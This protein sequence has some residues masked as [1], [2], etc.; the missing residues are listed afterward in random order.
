[1]DKLN[2]RLT[3]GRVTAGDQQPPVCQCGDHRVNL[4]VFRMWWSRRASTKLINGA[5]QAGRGNAGRFVAESDQR[6]D[7]P[8]YQQTLVRRQRLVD[9]IAP[10]G[11]PADHPADLL[12]RVMRQST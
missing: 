5:P 6:C 12:I 11:Y 3:A 10:A 8:A 9:L 4:T 2:D 7:N 1:M